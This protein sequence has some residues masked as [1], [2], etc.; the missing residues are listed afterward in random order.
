MATSHIQ[1]L[2]CKDNLTPG[3]AQVKPNLYSVKIVIYTAPMTRTPKIARARRPAAG[4]TTARTARK[5]GGRRAGP[6]G[7]DAPYHHGALREALLAAAERLLERDGLA[8]LTL[9]AVAREAGVSHAAPAHHF[10]DLSGLVSELAAIGFRQFNAAMVVAD[11]DADT[12]AQR[13]MARAK[14]YIAYAQAHPGMYGL[15][16]RT[17]RLDMSRASLREAATRHSQAWPARSA[18]SGRSRL[19]RTRC[20]SIR[21]PRSRAPGRWSTVSPCCCSMAGLP[22]SCGGCPREPTPKPCS[23]PCSE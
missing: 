20:R 16:F 3:T 13:A 6:V 23:M 17:E 8:G 2:H 11:A 12:P 22:T 4:V 10:G 1:S 21:P 7:K 18:R 14:A 5:A 19:P 9:R 15:M